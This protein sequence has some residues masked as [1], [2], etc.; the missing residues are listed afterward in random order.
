MQNVKINNKHKLNVEFSSEQ[1]KEIIDW[2]LQIGDE[3]IKLSPLQQN[4][5]VVG[6]WRK[7]RSIGSVGKKLAK[8]KKTK[9]R[10]WV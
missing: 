8:V 6:M 7:E 1:I 10:H 3:G 5:F 9:R 4:S 2:I